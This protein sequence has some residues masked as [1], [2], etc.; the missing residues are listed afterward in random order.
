MGLRAN[1]YAKIWKIEPQ[2]KYTKVQMSVSKKDKAT[3]EW[4]TE[5]SGRANFVGQAH[6]EIAKCKEKDR[7]KI[8]EFE[9]TNKYDKEKGLESTHY[10]VFKISDASGGTTQSAPQASKSPDV[11]V[12]GAADEMPF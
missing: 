10:S 9:V 4:K 5:W 8:E 12:E 2:E 7:I 11:A 3:G 1:C 6:T